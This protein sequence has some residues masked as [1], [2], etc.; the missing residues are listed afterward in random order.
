MVYSG[1][2]E[3]LGEIRS[4]W[5][6]W[7]V[8]CKHWQVRDKECITDKCDSVSR[9]RYTGRLKVRKKNHGKEIYG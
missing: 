7:L 8:E 9:N 4:L 3:G 1:L 6:E 2:I 5:V